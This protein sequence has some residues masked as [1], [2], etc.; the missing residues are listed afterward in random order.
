MAVR[1]ELR[2]EL[3]SGE[4]YS[5]VLNGPAHEVIQDYVQLKRDVNGLAQLIESE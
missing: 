3:K 1:I 4:T 2:G 5:V